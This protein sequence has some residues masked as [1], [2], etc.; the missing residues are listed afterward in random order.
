MMRR[1]RAYRLFLRASPWV[2]SSFRC[3]LIHSPVKADKKMKVSL[4]VTCLVDQ[5]FPEVGM[6]VVA[7][8]RKLGVE[9]DFP[10]EQT[11]CGQPAFNS[12]F[13]GEARELARRFIE[14]FENSEYV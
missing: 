3:C 7:V 14:I 11:C 5:F 9:V 2:D 10:A 13:A 1:S 12:G 4:F 8:L 6:S